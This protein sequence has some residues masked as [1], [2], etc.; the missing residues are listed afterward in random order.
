MTKEQLDKVVSVCALVEVPVNA[1]LAVM[2]FETAKTLSP[3]KRNHIGSVGLIQF[4]RD[5]AGVQYKTINGKKYFLDDLAKMS[6]IEQMDVVKEY[7][8]P[9]K[10]KLNTFI[11]VYLY[12]FFPI[13][14]GK[15]LDYVFQ[16]SGLSAS[17]IA[18]QNPI[19][20]K[21]KDGKITKSEVLNFFSGYYGQ[22]FNEIQQTID[23]KKIAQYLSI[24]LLIPLAVFFYTIVTVVLV[25]S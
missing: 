23:W 3:S 11:D 7:F 24:Y 5:K 12:V 22:F 18:Q 10:G 25:N 9:A 14:V 19:F 20:D 6:F 8:M 17:L 13:A 4:T 2:Y 16:T 21:N 15:G 1:L